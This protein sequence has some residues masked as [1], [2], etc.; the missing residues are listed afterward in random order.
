M[1]L[2][3]LVKEVLRLIGGSLPTTIE[4]ELCL[5]TTADS[6]FANPAEL[7]QVLMNLCTNAYHAM[8]EKGGC[9]QVSLSEHCGPLLGWTLHQGPLSAPLVRLTVRDT[10]TGIPTEI[11]PKIFEPFFTTKKQ[12]EGTG[13]GLAIVH[14]VVKRCK[15]A[16]S[17]ESALGRGT[18]FHVYLPLHSASSNASGATGTTESAAAAS[19][20]ASSGHHRVRVLYV[21][22]EFSVARLAERYLAR[23]GLDVKIENDSVKALAMLQTRVDDFDVL[24]TDQTM[25]SVSGMELAQQVL[26]LRP[27]FPVIMCTGYSET[28]SPEMAASAGIRGYLSK[29]VDYAEMAALI[30][31]CACNG[32]QATL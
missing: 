32:S 3:D 5:A 20:A 30:R 19:L 22:D 25:P 21:D 13:M 10:G 29:P 17:I 31:A 15:G 12:G 24:V 18:S 8:R 2:S 27:G 6:V 16:I 14:G 26:L 7:H 11:L 1:V 28:V 23:H 4:T 9:L